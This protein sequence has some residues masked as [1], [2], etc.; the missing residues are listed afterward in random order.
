MTN[1]NLVAAIRAGAGDRCALMEQ[2][3]K[4]NEGMIRKMANKAAC[5]GDL[6]DDLMQEGYF[7]LESAVSGFDPAAG[8][9]FITYFCTVLKWHFW[10]VQRS[11]ALPVS[12][13]A[14]LLD[15]LAKYKATK[16]ALEQ[17]QVEPVT[18]AQIA[19]AA[20]LTA[21]Q[22]AE[23]RLL[24]YQLHTV[25][26]DAPLT[27]ADDLTVGDLIPDGCDVAGEICD[28][29]E[30]EYNRRLLDEALQR[31][32]DETEREILQRYFGGEQLRRVADDMGLQ[33]QQAV[34]IQNK[35]IQKLRRDMQLRVDYYRSGDLYKYSYQRFRD[36]GLSSVEF[37]A[38]RNERL[39]DGA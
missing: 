1:E 22:A 4:Q 21:A 20:D 3:Y 6:F 10:G 29:A 16:A 34:G 12:V 39:N 18:V 31:D 35:A 13:P 33:Y 23:T 30:K 26:L 5:G 8:V 15:R 7:A 27:D 9:Q 11:A 17:A 24:L 14:Y 37:I 36:S 2:L 38:E 19:Q 32:L 25:S 28:D